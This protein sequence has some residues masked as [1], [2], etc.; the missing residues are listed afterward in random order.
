MCSNWSI[1]EL[2]PTLELLYPAEYAQS[3]VIRFYFIR[4]RAIVQKSPKKNY[5][6][7]T[8]FQPILIEFTNHLT[9]YSKRDNTNK[10]FDRCGKNMCISF[11]VNSPYYSTLKDDSPINVFACSTEQIIARGKKYWQYRVLANDALSEN[12]VNKILASEQYNHPIID[13]ANNDKEIL[14]LLELNG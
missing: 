2:M 7:T 12:V 10:L 13:E 4:E 8:L 14:D 3:T 11:R 6:D 5:L 9:N 1:N